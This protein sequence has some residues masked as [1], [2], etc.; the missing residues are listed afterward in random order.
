[1][2]QPDLPPDPQPRTVTVSGAGLLHW[3]GRAKAG[4]VHIY[5]MD[6]SQKHNGHYTLH[7]IWLA[8]RVLYRHGQQP[9]QDAAL[10]PTPPQRQH[11]AMVEA[12]EL[13]K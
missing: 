8:G 4:E 3:G 5:R 12:L 11:G 10:K 9:P 13:F 1:M 6:L 7:L 2:N